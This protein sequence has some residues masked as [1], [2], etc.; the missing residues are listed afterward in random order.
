M[1]GIKKY[2]EWP[3]IPQLYVDGEFLGGYDII[4]IS[5]STTIVEVVSK[6][7]RGVLSHR[8]RNVVIHF[9]TGFVAFQSSMYREGELR[10]LIAEKGLKEDT[11]KE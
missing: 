4:V 5:S 7:S 6:I 2:S 1:P 11:K 10:E 8:L 3:T 9:P